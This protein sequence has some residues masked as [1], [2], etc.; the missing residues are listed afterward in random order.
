MYHS[1]KHIMECRCMA[2]SQA[3]GALQGQTQAGQTPVSD[4]DCVVRATRRIVKALS[5]PAPSLVR[6]GLTENPLLFVCTLVASP[7][8]SEQSMVG[9]LAGSR[10]VPAPVM[11]MDV[12][13]PLASTW[14]VAVGAAYAGSVPAAQAPVQV[15]V[16]APAV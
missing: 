6:N 11:V 8:P 16:A 7:V 10:F 12:T 4:D 13:A 2:D 1:R 3:V 15:T 14:H 5:V 9:G